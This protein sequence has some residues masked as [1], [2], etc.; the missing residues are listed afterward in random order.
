MDHAG[1][2]PPSKAVWGHVCMEKQSMRRTLSFWTLRTS[3]DW[4]VD[5]Y[6][7]ALSE[8]FIEDLGWGRMNSTPGSE[9]WPCL[10]LH[11]NFS[12]PQFP[13][14]H[15]GMM[16]TVP[17]TQGS[18]ECCM[19][20]NLRPKTINASGSSEPLVE[21]CLGAPSRSEPVSLSPNCPAF[22]KLFLFPCKLCMS[23]ALC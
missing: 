12:G 2:L 13:C 9:S 1:Y 6:Y 3:V 18:Y 10:Y 4:I 21:H 20:L 7:L 8:S 19:R 16:K 11:A 22:L 15:I 17:I 23:S 5:K 14:L